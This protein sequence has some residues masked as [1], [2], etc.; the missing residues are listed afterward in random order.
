MDKIISS[1]SVEQV[2]LFLV[3]GAAAIKGAIDFYDWAHAKLQN[4]F[5]KEEKID[6][7]EAQL[8]DELSERDKKITELEDNQSQI[9]ESL[10]NMNKKVDLLIDS[11]KD[12]IKS[13]ITREHHFF[14]YVQGW[15]DDYSLECCERR[16]DHYVHENGN[17]FIEG[18]MNDLRKLPKNPPSNILDNSARHTS[19]NRSYNTTNITNKE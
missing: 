2:V 11:D 6:N 8:L 13:F 9:I 12:D 19:I 3:L 14:C 5:K 4:K 15:I 18:F 17:S 16:Y 10:D 7:T 1:F